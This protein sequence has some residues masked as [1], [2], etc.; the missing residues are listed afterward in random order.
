[1]ANSRPSILDE[2]TYDALR[3]E[4]ASKEKAA[5]IANASADPD[6]NPSKTGGQAPPCEDWTYNDLYAQAQEIGIH[7]R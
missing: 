2:D 1:M 7:G 5:R 3:R 6:R 4:G